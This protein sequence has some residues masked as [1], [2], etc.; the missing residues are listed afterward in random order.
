MRGSSI[1]VEA[2][3]GEGNTHHTTLVDKEGVP[4]EG[5]GISK[6]L[7]EKDEEG[8][9]D[10]SLVAISDQF[11]VDKV[12]V[13]I[14]GKPGDDGVDGDHQEDSDNVTLLIGVG[15]VGHVKVDESSGDEASHDGKA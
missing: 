12:G 13:E 3:K 11:I 4:L 15:V 14:V 2:A 6:V 7:K 10:K 5:G 8:G 1:I 9:N